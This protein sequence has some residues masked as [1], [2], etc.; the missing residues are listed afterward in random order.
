[1]DPSSF[2]C[3]FEF[4]YALCFLVVGFYIKDHAR[5]PGPLLA[6]SLNSSHILTDKISQTKIRKIGGINLV[7]LAFKKDYFNNFLSP[8]SYSMS[9]IVPLPCHCIISEKKARV[10][11][12]SLILRMLIYWKV[13]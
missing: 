1:M 9:K 10:I 7:S 5:V 6:P 11:A 4:G 3:V 2:A 8:Q 12:S 13:K